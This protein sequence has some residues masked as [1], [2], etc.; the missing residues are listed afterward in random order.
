MYDW[1]YLLP[2]NTPIIRLQHHKPLAPN[3]Q[4]IALHSLHPLRISFVFVR[5]DD[6]LHFLRCYVEG[7]GGGPDGCAFAVE[8]GGAVEV[9]CADQ[10]GKEGMLVGVV[11]T[12]GVVWWC[13][14]ARRGEVC[15][16]GLRRLLSGF[17]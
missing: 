17:G 3:M 4:P 8:D 1:T 7:G 9:A 5:V 13:G 14:W 2:I 12:D 16:F 15:T 10:A 11:G 6:F